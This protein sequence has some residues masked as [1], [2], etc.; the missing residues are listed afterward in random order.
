MN[1]AIPLFEVNPALD[2][3]ALASSFA[4]ERRVQIRYAPVSA[5]TSA[6]TFFWRHCGSGAISQ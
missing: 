6:L 2:R 3:A 1:G 5:A 4:A